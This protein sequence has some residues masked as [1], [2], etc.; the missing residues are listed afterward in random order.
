MF[1][2]LIG[3][4]LHITNTF[5]EQFGKKDFYEVKARI[6]ERYGKPDGLYDIQHIPGKPC[7]SCE[8]TGGLYEPGGCYKCWGDGWYKRPFWVPLKRYHL[9]RYVFHRPEE[10]SYERPEPGVTKIHGYIKHPHYSRRKI[11]IAGLILFAMFDRKLFRQCLAEEWDRLWVVRILSRRCIDCKRRVWST[12]RWRCRVCQVV[13][14]RMPKE[15][16][17]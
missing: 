13:L 4:L 2:R 10:R 11:Q 3:R 16:P 6:L 7:W 5:P 14:D 8:G 15:V 9:G 1:R 17:F 12:K